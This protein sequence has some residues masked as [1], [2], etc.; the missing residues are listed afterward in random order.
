[1][2]IYVGTKDMYCIAYTYTAFLDKS[3]SKRRRNTQIS[4]KIEEEE[5]CLKHEQEA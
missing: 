4:M 3:I 5:V 1:V 2:Y